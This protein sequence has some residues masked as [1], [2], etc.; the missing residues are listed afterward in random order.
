MHFCLS[1]VH[2]FL[3]AEMQFYNRP[4]PSIG[5]SVR[6]SVRNAVEKWKNEHSRCF[7]G[8][9][10]WLGGAWVVDGGWMPLPTYPQLYFDPASLVFVFLFE[11]RPRRDRWPMLSHIGEIFPSSSSPSTPSDP[12]ILALGPKSKSRG[13]NSSLKAQILALSLKSQP[14][15]SNPNLKAQI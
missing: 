15:G 5:P 9:V 10:C 1:V 11:Q 4:C 2:P 7:F 3:E 13:P 12:H 14:Q 6:P 8:Y